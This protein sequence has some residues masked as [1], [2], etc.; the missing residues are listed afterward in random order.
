MLATALVN[1]PCNRFSGITARWSNATHAMGRVQGRAFHAVAP[2]RGG[3]AQGEGLIRV[4]TAE[5]VSSDEADAL[6]ARTKPTS[7]SRTVAP[8]LSSGSASL[9]AE[10]APHGTSARTTRQSRAENMPPNWALALTGLRPAAHRQGVGLAEPWRQ[11]WPGRLHPP[12]ERVR[13][14]APPAVEAQ[15][16]RR[17]EGQGPGGRGR[18]LRRAAS[19]RMHRKLSCKASTSGTDPR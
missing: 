19:R 6:A 15:G 9:G 8:P 4:I 13:A 10:R 5:G 12:C 7:G 14:Q 17:T 18:F 2:A 1:K 16:G 3:C 11:G